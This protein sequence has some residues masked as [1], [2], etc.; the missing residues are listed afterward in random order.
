MTATMSSGVK[1]TSCNK[2][3]HQLKQKKS[4]ALP[5][6]PMYLCQDCMDNKR[7]PR[8]FLVLAGRQAAERGENPVESLGYWIKAH[9]YIGD[10]ITLRELV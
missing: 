5:G 2:V 1:C 9:R 10:S 7:E 3:K 8:A 4:K 6:V